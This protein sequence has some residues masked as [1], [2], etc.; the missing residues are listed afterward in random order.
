MCEKN[1]M[2]FREKEYNELISSPSLEL[3]G[4]MNMHIVCIALK[5]THMYIYSTDLNIQTKKCFLFDNVR[6]AYLLG[7]TV[8]R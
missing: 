8:S 1:D 5:Y 3:L 6:G 2:L 4:Y 7:T